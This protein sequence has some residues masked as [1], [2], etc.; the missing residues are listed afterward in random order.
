MTFLIARLSLYYLDTVGQV[1]TTAYGKGP[2]SDILPSNASNAERYQVQLPYGESYVSASS[3]AKN[4]ATNSKKEENGDAVMSEIDVNTQP[5]PSTKIAVNGAADYCCLFGTEQM[6]IFMRLYCTIV[7]ILELASSKSVR[8]DGA[9]ISEDKDG[10]KKMG[11]DAG[12]K[13]YTS[14][15]NKVKEAL[16]SS[17]STS[18]R[19]AFESKCRF[20]CK[21]I[22][23]L[24]TC[25][26]DLVKECINVVDAVVKEDLCETLYNCSTDKG[27]NIQ[28]TRKRSLEAS[29]SA[30]YRLQFQRKGEVGLYF[31]H[32][33]ADADLLDQPLLI[34][35]SAQPEV[36]VAKK[37]DAADDDDSSSDNER[38]V[39]RF[40]V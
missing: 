2:I 27:P 12:E 29:N 25:V 10:D 14:F 40:R 24:L 32:L 23:Y 1:V 34:P 33:P 30:S 26:P 6:Y 15:I 11:S 22:A 17:S 39:K 19:T 35:E 36:G 9:N 16:K 18:D 3:I 4:S 38:D 37:R 20:Y 7:K 28:E 31:C 5:S 13:C 8:E 21:D